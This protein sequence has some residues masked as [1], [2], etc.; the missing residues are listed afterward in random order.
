MSFV[1]DDKKRVKS[2]EMSLEKNDFC[3]EKR[4]IKQKEHN[5]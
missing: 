3:I 5:V 1:C 2:E 4:E